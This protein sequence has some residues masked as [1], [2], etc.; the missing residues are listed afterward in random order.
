MIASTTTAEVERKGNWM[1]TFSGRQFWPLDPRPAEVYI[2]DI[3]HALSL[4]CRY[5]GHCKFMY[6]VAQHSIY[7]SHQLEH[8]S[9]I[10]AMAGLLHDAAEAYCADIVRPLK[11]HL[12]EYVVVELRIQSAIGERFDID[13]RLFETGLVK[14]ADMAVGEAEKRWIMGPPPTPW[15]PF[16]EEAKIRIPPWTCEQAETAFLSR[17]HALQARLAEGRNVG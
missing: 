2:E 6:S 1:Q 11:R 8:A 14:L 5:N 12:Y 15:E 13:P 16:P 17:F 10:I 4:M 9:P 3:A 7:V